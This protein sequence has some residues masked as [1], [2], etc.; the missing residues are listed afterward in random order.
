MDL[1]ETAVGRKKRISLI[2]KNKFLCND[3]IWLG[4][5]CCFDVAGQVWSPDSHVSAIVLL[6][7]VL[8]QDTGVDV[9]WLQRTG[10][11]MT[12]GEGRVGKKGNG[13][14]RGDRGGGV[15]RASGD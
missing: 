11:I 1:R 6:A 4:W 5:P 15:W 12:C 13:G 14:C 10:N 8:F 9:G 7:D 2:R 3:M